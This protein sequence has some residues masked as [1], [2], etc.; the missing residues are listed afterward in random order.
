LLPLRR[1]ATGDCGRDGCQREMKKTTPA[2]T[3][4]G[5]QAHIIIVPDGQGNAF[6]ECR[7]GSVGE[8]RSIGRLP[9]LPVIAGH[10][11]GRS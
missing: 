1:G 9:V 3:H 5:D 6:Y 11:V 8:R 10:H 4:D 2:G 7:S